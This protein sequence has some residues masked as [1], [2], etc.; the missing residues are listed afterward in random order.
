MKK[1]LALLLAGMMILAMA[2]CGNG[3]AGNSQPPADTPSQDAAT[4]TD[5]PAEPTDAPA[6]PTDAPTDTPEDPGD[7]A[8]DLTAFYNTMFPEAV[9]SGLTLVPMEGDMLEYAYP[10]LAAMDL[11]QMV[12]YGPLMSAVAYEIA[13]VEAPD[14]ATASAVKALLDSR[15]STMQ[16]DQGNY[17]AVTEM[18]Q[19][20]AFAEED[21]NYL[22]L[23]VGENAQEE[24][25]WFHTYIENASI[26]EPAVY[27]PNS[28]G[29]DD[30]FG[31]SEDADPEGGGGVVPPIFVPGGPDN[32]GV[33]GEVGGGSDEEV[34]PCEPAPE[35][36]ADLEGFFD[37]VTM[38]H[39]CN[40]GWMDD[41]Y[42]KD[43]I[44]G[45]VS[46]PAYQRAFYAPA[47]TGV[48][49]EML[50]VQL[51][52]AEDVQTLTDTLNEYVQNMINGGAD[53]PSTM[54]QWEKNAR[55]VSNGNYVMLV[56]HGDSDAIVDEFNALFA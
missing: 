26:R 54:E 22:M 56:V 32:P 17:P 30:E 47:M 9:A 34:L 25:N 52:N 44:A 7:D 11:K 4:P 15:I 49:Q 53:Y 46:L 41:L 6:E 38:A 37:S 31:G 42:L 1:L 3:G 55:V 24:V 16:N 39:D 45:V 29:V 33:G 5:P 19:T 23:V 28:G 21:G 12:V 48:A 14:A 13:L 50:L 8:R 10:G 35:G 18:W 51:Q 20:S 27:D 43:H 40:L 2:A 36:S